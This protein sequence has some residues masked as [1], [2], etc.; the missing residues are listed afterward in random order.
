MR[1]ISKL[2]FVMLL[3]A[4]TASCGRSNG[5]AGAETADADSC[6]WVGVPLAD[7]FILLDGD[8][9]YAYGTGDTGI[10]VFTS[11]DLVHWTPAGRALDQANSYGDHWFW[12]PEIYKVGDR[13]LMYYTAEEHVCV[14]EATSPTGPFKQAEHKPV[15]AW[16]ERNIDNTLFIDDDGTPYMF[17]DRLV[18]EGLQINVVQLNPDL[19]TVAPDAEVTKCIERSQDWEQDN[20]NEGSYVMKHG[21]T[22]YMTYSGNGYTNPGYGLGVATAKSPRGPWTKYEGNPV[23]QYPANDALGRLEGVG[24]SAM[25]RDKEGNLRIVFHAHK[26]PGTV[27]PREMY[28]SD[29]TFTDDPV[30]VMQISQERMFKCLTPEQSNNLK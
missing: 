29:V 28:V 12:A 22:Y 5:S 17:F 15:F 2:T 11:D 4:M 1:L 21:D 24:H 16:D 19:L 13:Y 9:Y 7:P 20:V 6:A 18:P 26:E 8:T 3:V 25:F 14:A 27:H 23:F 30:P 10:D